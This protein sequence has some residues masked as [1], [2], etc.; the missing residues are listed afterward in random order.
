MA[1][2]TAHENCY[3]PKTKSARAACRRATIAA[4]NKNRNDA[5]ELIEGYYDNSL[6]TEAFAYA[7]CAL[8]DRTQNPLL[9]EAKEGYYDNSLEI[10]EMANLLY[11]AKF[12]L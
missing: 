12:E 3:H 1:A 8:A 2:S 6:D 11:R 9:L 4:Q 7:V 5:N 10:E